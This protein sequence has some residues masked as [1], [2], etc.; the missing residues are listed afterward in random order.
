M[1]NHLHIFTKTKSRSR[2]VRS[3]YLSILRAP[4]LTC[5]YT[6]ISAISCAIVPAGGALQC[7][8]HQARTQVHARMTTF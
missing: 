2:L 6:Y 3:V 7:G 5:T 1:S 8:R 4:P